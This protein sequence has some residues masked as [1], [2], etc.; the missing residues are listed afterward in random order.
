MFEFQNPAAFFVLLLIPLL[1]IL[2]LLKIFSKI[3]YPAVLADWNGTVFEY[4]GKFR[5]FLSKLA[6][7]LIAASFIFA[8]I[9]FAGPVRITQ[10]KVYTSLGTDI[11]FVVDTSPS[12]AASDVNNQQRL[13]VAKNT[14][15]NLMSDYDGVRYGFIGFGSSACVYVPPTHNYQVFTDQI[16]QIPVGILGNGSAIGDGLSTAVAHLAS[17]SAP[18]KCIILLTDGENNAGEIHPET[19]AK[20]A[21]EN[22]ITL[23]VVGVGSKGTVP[24]EYTD[25]VTGKSYSGY[26][27]S[28]FNPASLKKIAAI[29]N[30]RYYEVRTSEELRSTLNTVAKNEN[31]IQNFTYRSVTTDLYKTAILISIILILVAFFISYVILQEK[32]NFHIKKLSIVRTILLGFSFLMLIL[33]W[34]GFSWGTYLEPVQ[35]SGTAVSFVFDISN[36]MKAKDCANN[37]SRLE[38]ASTYAQRLLDKM[39]GTSV[40]VVLAK[41]EG[42]AAIPLTED[43]AMLE[44][45]ISVLT[46]D[47]MTSPGSNLA[48]GILCAKDSFPKN[49][50]NAG[51]IWLFTD[52]EETTDSLAT[53]LEDC[54]KS[55][56]S[57]TIIGFGST[58]ETE[59]IAGDGHT[60][61]NSALREELVIKAIEA[62]TAKLSIYKNHTP[63]TYIDSTDKGSALYLLSQLSINNAE[64]N[65]LV[66]YETKPVPRYKL[67]L[68]LSLMAF[69]FSYIC[70]EFNLKKVFGKKKIAAVTGSLLVCISLFTGCSDSTLE[71]LSGSYSVQQKQY[72]K[73]ISHFLKSVQNATATE[74]QTVLDYSLYDLGTAYQL[75]GEKEAAIERYSQISE[76]AAEDVK[77]AAYYNCGVIAHNNEDYD[78]A[79]DYFRKAL[80]IDNTKISA[81]INLEL[82]MQMAEAKGRQHQSQTIPASEGNSNIPDIE[83]GVFEHVKENDQKRWKNSQAPENINLE[84]D[85]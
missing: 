54:I 77:F 23:Y 18:Q 2:R 22:D 4:K 81:K 62:A 10:E 52:G 26:L 59:I 48:K 85:Y 66:T 27:D 70:V 74:N 50:A 17:S 72:R 84:N 44:S 64:D 47:L 35:K 39:E 43:K 76:S 31:V 7:F 63:V 20:L 71:V 32:I 37:T 65:Q 1:Y 41:G 69:A 78:S 8:V 21:A 75:S 68:I 67:F 25:P 11:M 24:I 57:V 53:A 46:P 55:G 3:T 33:A 45:L 9:A 36:S 79:Q 83:E 60:R 19:A 42:I 30:G 49:F 58:D 80:E 15:I 51:R 28:D 16:L 14:I 5:K 13:T 6:K 34:C 56:I 12:M 38:A 29:G 61:V 82:S 73:G 40:S